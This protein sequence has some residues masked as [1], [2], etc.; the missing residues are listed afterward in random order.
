[1]NETLTMGQ[2]EAAQANDLN[3]ISAVIS[4]TESRVTQLAQRAARRMSPT[5]PGFAEYLDEFTQVARIAVWECIPRFSGE[6]VD[7]FFA[8]IY[9]TADAKLLDAVRKERNGES[10]VDKDAVK[11]FASMLEMA[12]GDLHLAEKFAQTVPPKGQ[13][14]G[15][16]RAMAARLSWQGR[17][18]LDAPPVRPHDKRPGENYSSGVGAGKAMRSTYGVPDDLVTAEDINA[19]ASR[20]RHAI[21]FSILDVMGAAQSLVIRHSFGIGGYEFFGRGDSG[22]D[23]GLAAHIGS[24]VPRVRDAR[25]KGLK[26][27]A[28]RYIAATATSE[29]E[30]RELTAIAEQNLSEGGRK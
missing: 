3:A 19:E 24:T 21:V 27:F 1:M 7:S 14:L 11:V 16:D 10:G 4:A 28:R 9:S 5:G 25:T 18:S 22:D 12:D 23:V 6:T 15:P 17:V 8:Y 26:A 30:A 20:V 29:S 13:R 2:I